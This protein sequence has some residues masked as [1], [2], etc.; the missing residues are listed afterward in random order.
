MA[1]LVNELVWSHSR[2]NAFDGCR[3]AYWFAYYGSWGGWEKGA[4]KRAYDA[5]IQKK[6]ASRAMWIGTSVHRAAEAELRR[7]RDGEEPWTVEDAVGAARRR[8]EADL[9]ESKDGRW[10]QRP[11]KRLGLTEHYYEEPIERG[12]LEADI[13]E[14]ERQVRVLWD[15]RLFRRLR[16]V[17]DRIVEL[18]DLRR[19]R[20]GDAE[21]WVV[22]DAMVLD[23]RGG[24]AIVDW[25]TGAAHAESD[26]DAQ[27]GVYG[28]YASNVRGIPVANLTAF[29]VNLRLGEEARH[30]VGV[31]ALGAAESRIGASMAAMRAA[32]VDVAANRA[33]EPAFPPLPEGD[34]E[35]RRCNFRG[36]CG[37]S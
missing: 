23:G 35:C 30:A 31:A 29:H 8:A 3:R 14:I 21:V 10:L 28:L 24:A 33:E 36:V 19:F 1:D 16:E 7:C 17:P 9:A 12:G 18:E 11:A 4:P 32:L 15:Q 27:L 20:V 37:R 25:K 22:L 2:A 13:A 26:L 34:A 6:L 5:W